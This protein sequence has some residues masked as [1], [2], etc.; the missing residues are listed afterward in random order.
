MIFSLF[1]ETQRSTL[2]SLT[3]D[4]MLREQLELASEVTKYPVEDGGPDVSDHITQGN[5]VLEISGSISASDIEGYE[6]GGCFSKLMDV[7]EMLR[8]MHADRQPI[9]VVTGLGIYQEMGFTG[10]TVQR[11][12]GNEKGGAWLDIDTSLIKVIKVA[13]EEADLPPE[14]V[15][16]DAKGK[17]GGTEKKGSSNNGSAAKEPSAGNDRS[18]LKSGK[19]MGVSGVREKFG[20]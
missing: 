16:G 3:L 8:E 15:A 4:V 5:E 2:G 14:Q 7:I 9:T 1:Y 10:L 11:N 20:L 18:I 19:E 17:A 13:L 12:S 6:F